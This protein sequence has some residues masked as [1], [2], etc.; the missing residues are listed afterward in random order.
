MFAGHPH[1]GHQ[2]HSQRS[3]GGVASAAAAALA[4]GDG[5]SPAPARLGFM[6]GHVLGTPSHLAPEAFLPGNLLDGAVDI[7]RCGR[8]HGTVGT[9][10]V[11]QTSACH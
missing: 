10:F 6:S 11:T 3:L 1:Q 8:G 2:Q 9:L 5:S 7:Y 4:G